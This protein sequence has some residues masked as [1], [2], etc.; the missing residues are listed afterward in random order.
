MSKSWKTLG[1]RIIRR[2]MAYAVIFGLGLLWAH[3]DRAKCEVDRV[4]TRVIIEGW[5]TKKQ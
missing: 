1:T 5:S 2:L 4:E 3:W